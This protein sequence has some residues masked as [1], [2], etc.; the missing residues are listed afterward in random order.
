M[1]P[2]RVISP[3]MDIWVDESHI[4][5]LDQTK[6]NDFKVG[7]RVFVKQVTLSGDYPDS[8]E[9]KAINE[10]GRVISI[11]DQ[12]C[13]SIEVVTVTGNGWYVNPEEIEHTTYDFKI[14]DDVN[15]SQVFGVDITGRGVISEIRN[16][17][18][19]VVY[20]PKDG[21]TYS[22]NSWLVEFEH[23]EH[24]CKPTKY[25]VGDRVWVKQ[26]T[27]GEYG[28]DERVPVAEF[29]T[30][31][32]TKSPFETQPYDVKLDDGKHYV[33]NEAEMEEATHEFKVGDRVRVLDT[34]IHTGPMIGVITEVDNTGYYK[35]S[36]RVREDDS[37]F[38]AW[39]KPCNSTLLRV[40]DPSHECDVVSDVTH[41]FS[42]GDLVFAKQTTSNRVHDQVVKITDLYDE[43]GRY[44]VITSD[45]DTGIT[46]DEYGGKQNLFSIEFKGE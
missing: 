22:G 30:I 43:H 24:L 12:R 39:C 21:R 34:I 13:L 18:T 45:G 9:T 16:S 44:K 10:F 3:D 20:F 46:R 29:G 27:V 35:N 1:H 19:C 26:Y 25:G 40:C 4:T 32:G 23:M 8:K 14:G 41:Q 28:I 6:T 2:Y 17:D 36:I 5:K 11:D 31:I 15:V 7:D 42:V 37:C 33:L 38:T